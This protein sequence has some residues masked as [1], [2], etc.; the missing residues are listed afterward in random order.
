MEKDTENKVMDLFGTIE[1]TENIPA[2]KVD[3]MDGLRQTIFQFFNLRTE[4]IADLEN[5]RS[6]VTVALERKLDS[7]QL[8]FKDLM[9]LF[10]LISSHLNSASD[11]IIS[12]FKPVPGAESLLAKTLS[13]DEKEESEKDFFESLNSDQLANVQKLLTA[14]S[15]INRGEDVDKEE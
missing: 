4:K 1:E 15:L 5:F 11:S 2:V 13:K 3:I 7:D 8:E 6:K 9:A 14:L 12:I 10:S